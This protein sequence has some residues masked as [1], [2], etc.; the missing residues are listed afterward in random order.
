M[1]VLGKMI[2]DWAKDCETIT[3]EVW[4]WLV[5]LAEDVDVVSQILCKYNKYIIWGTE[6]CGQ[7]EAV[8]IE[9]AIGAAA[10]A[11]DAGFNCAKNALNIIDYTTKCTSA[12]TDI[13]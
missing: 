4:H 12:I 6:L 2:D 13:E 1:A 8:P 11:Y 9:K 7:V 3:E 10:C 5:T